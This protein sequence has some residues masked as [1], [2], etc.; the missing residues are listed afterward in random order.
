M[1]TDI[2]FYVEKQVYRE[3]KSVW[4]SADQWKPNEYAGEEGEPPLAFDYKSSFYSGRNY[5]LFAILANVRNGHGFAGCDTGNGFVSIGEP[6]GLPAD[7]SEQTKAESDSMGIDGHSHS[8][9][10]VAELLAYDWTQVTKLR[11]YVTAAEYYQWNR[12][13]RGA[14][15][16]P[17]GYCGGVSG[18][19][20]EKVSE[21]ELR[22]RIEELTGG[23][24]RQQ[25]AKVKEA[26]PNVYCRVEW[27]QPY[28]KVARDFLAE[29]MPR[30]WRLGR[31]DDVRI[32]F[33]FDN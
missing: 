6:R 24:W 33:F 5:N 4:T 3:Q 28:Y 18:G 17:E 12:W 11:G 25:E 8:W 22:R 20:V 32:V 26:M 23:D 1:G 10:T 14:G 19:D 16:G 31:P 15:D 29:T 9:F 21:D 13:R 2:H 7:V 30:L 27:E